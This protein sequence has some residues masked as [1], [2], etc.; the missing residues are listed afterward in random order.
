MNKKGFTLIELLVVIV[1]IGILVAIALPNFI[2]IKDKARE[3][4]IKQN[5]HSIQLAVERYATDADGNYPYYLYGGDTRFN[6]GTHM[7][8]AGQYMW[9]FPE[10]QHPFDMFYLNLPADQWCYA[11]V[12]SWQDLLSSDLQAG[13]GDTLA[14]E[15][16]MPKYPGNPFCQGKAAAQYSSEFHQYSSSSVNGMAGFGGFDGTC[17]FNVGWF[18]DNPMIH[19][20]PGPQL[21]AVICELPGQFFYHPRWTDGVT[22]LGHLIKQQQAVDFS[23]GYWDYG[24]WT[25]QP[26][27]PADANDVSSLDVSAYDLI[28]IGSPRTKGQDLDD[29]QYNSGLIAENQFRTGY[30]TQG[31]ERNPYV[32][33]GQS[34]WNAPQDYAERPFSDSI[35]DFFIIHLSSGIDKKVQNEINRS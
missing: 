18:G 29:S 15:G 30:V 8:I 31:Q 24:G 4:E 32:M 3:A 12:G 7:A 17:M 5:L 2:K 10:A 19:K 25:P 26:P 23:T 27:N 9:V 20:F 21:D 22:N 14:Y 33:S 6:E 28:A 16:Y 11:R 34:P 13:F 35:P 1:I